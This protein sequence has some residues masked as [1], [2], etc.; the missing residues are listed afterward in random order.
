M[1]NNRDTQLLQS[2]ISACFNNVQRIEHTVSELRGDVNHILFHMKLQKTNLAN[3]PR[4]TPIP[5]DPNKV[6][7]I[8]RIIRAI[9]NK[10]YW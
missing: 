7:V 6:G 4:F 1:K 10:R 8:R 2:N 5:K 3:L 9:L